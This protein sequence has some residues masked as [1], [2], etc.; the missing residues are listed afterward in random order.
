[1]EISTDKPP[2]IH[3]KNVPIEV[4]KAICDMQS[5]KKKLLNRNYGQA[6]AIYSIIRAWIGYKDLSK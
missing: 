3:L 2:S 6:E 5:E 1:M 4:Y